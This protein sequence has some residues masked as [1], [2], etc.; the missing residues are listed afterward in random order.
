MMLSVPEPSTATLSLLSLA[1]LAFR[2][3][4]N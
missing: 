2:R 1:V 4:R 3:R